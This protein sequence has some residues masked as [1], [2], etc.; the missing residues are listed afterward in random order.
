MTTAEL[1]RMPGVDEE[2][3]ARVRPVSEELEILCDR[4]PEGTMYPEEC[5]VESLKAYA[6]MVR[7]GG[8]VL[9]G[10]L[11]AVGGEVA[12]GRELIG[13]AEGSADKQQLDV[14]ARAG[15]ILQLIHGFLLGIDDIF[16]ESEL[17][18]NRPTVHTY[19]SEF[20]A[21]ARGLEAARARK[22]GSDLTVNGGIMTGYAAQSLLTR[23]DVPPERMVLAMRCLSD[24]LFLTGVGQSRDM[25]PPEDFNELDENELIKT[26]TLKTAYYTFLLP[27][28]MGAALSGVDETELRTFTE[29]AVNAGLA[30]QLVDDLLGVFGDRSKVGK[31]V[32]SD[33]KEKKATVL[34]ARAIAGA[35][36][37]DRRFLLNS[38]GNPN[39]TAEEFARDKEIIT[40]TGAR[41]Q[42]EEMAW[43]RAA[44]AQQ[45]VPGLPE[46]F[47]QGP[48][49]ILGGVAAGSVLRVA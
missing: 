14:L 19:L 22:L 3:R 45:S 38:L 46:R 10:G 43:Q 41:Q 48:V 39:L 30:F 16:D 15:A 24:N 8:K 47:R 34:I 35:D 36:R 40:A 27:L 42:V 5:T 32:D 26:A 7:D 11:T 49:H 13:A 4:L 31:P 9:R 21:E 29:Y 6:A 17:R 37:T 33:I 12:L 28:Q 23:L 20:V 18:R 44:A 2:F 1:L 25:V